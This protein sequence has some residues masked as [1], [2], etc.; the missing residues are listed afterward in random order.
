MLKHGPIIG[1][2]LSVEIDLLTLVRG[3]ELAQSSTAGNSVQKRQLR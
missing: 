3:P 1:S 2:G